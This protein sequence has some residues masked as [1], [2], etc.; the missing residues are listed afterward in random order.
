[1]GLKLQTA[2]LYSI[3]FVTQ[4]CIFMRQSTQTPRRK[5]SNS[6]ESEMKCK[7][8]GVGIVV[9]STSRVN[10]ETIKRCGNSKQ[11]QRDGTRPLIQKLFVKRNVIVHLLVSM[12]HY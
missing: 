4:H 7:Y 6:V 9:L 2:A 8:I 1:M 11:R 5:L 3:F 12:L 10:L